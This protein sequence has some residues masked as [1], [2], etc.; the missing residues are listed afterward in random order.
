[1]NGTGSSFSVT[2]NDLTLNVALTFSGMFVGKQDVILNAAGKTA[3]SSFVAKG[4]WTP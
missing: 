2:G 3:A 1:V 4:T